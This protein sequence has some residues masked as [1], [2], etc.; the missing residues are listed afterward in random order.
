M[1]W[2]ARAAIVKHEFTTERALSSRLANS[3]SGPP[4]KRKGGGGSASRNAPLPKFDVMLTTYEM[5]TA[6]PYARP[7]HHPHLA[8]TITHTA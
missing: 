8:H 6:N 4:K 2:Q 1:V 5:L 3:G 7:R